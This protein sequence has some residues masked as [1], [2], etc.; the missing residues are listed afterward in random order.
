LSV[1]AG[2][3]PEVLSSFGFVSARHR[4]PSRLARTRHQFMLA[5]IH[6][7]PVDFP[8]SLFGVIL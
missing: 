1:G 3:L 8:Q 4:Y 5:V 7:G 6:H 2:S